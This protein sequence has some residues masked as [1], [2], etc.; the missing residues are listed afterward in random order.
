[1]GETHKAFL[2]G[3][4]SNAAQAMRLWGGHR[5]EWCGLASWAGGK[6]VWPARARWYIQVVDL[7]AL[8]GPG[9]PPLLGALPRDCD[10]TH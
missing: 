2:S 3:H 1:M 7:W 9:G 4:L 8:L 5:A 10:E 6:A